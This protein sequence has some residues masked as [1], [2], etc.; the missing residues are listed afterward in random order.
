MN[1]SYNSV[2]FNSIGLENP[3][4]L[5]DESMVYVNK[6]WINQRNIN[7]QGMMTGNFNQITTKQTALVNMFSTDF[8]TL[9]V[10]SIPS[11]TYCK[12]NNITFPESNYQNILNYSISLLSYGDQFNYINSGVLDPVNEISISENNDGTFVVS[13]NASA[14][15]INKSTSALNAAKNFVN[16]L[17]GISQYN[18]GS[19]EQFNNELNNSSF[20]LKNFSE[21]IDRINGSCSIKE[22]YIFNS[23]LNDINPAD[24]ILK[25]SVE[26]R[27]GLRDDFATADVRGTIEYDKN[28]QPD[29]SEVSTLANDGTFKGKA[30]AVL[31]GS[32]NAI[33]ESFN[34]NTEKGKLDFNF[35]Y[36]NNV[37]PQPYFD[38]KLSFKYDKIYSK[39]V[40]DIS[41]PVIVKGNLDQRNTQ[42]DAFL[43]AIPNMETYLYN[44]V[45][46]DYST[47]CSAVGSN[48]Y[49]LRP[50]ANNLSVRR[51]LPKGTLEI[52][53][54]FDDGITAWPGFISN[55]FSINYNPT[56]E[57][58]YPKP[59]CLQNGYYILLQPDIWT[60]PNLSIRANGLL[61]LG[62]E[63]NAEANTKSFEQAIKTA[64]TNALAT[65]EI[66]KSE[67]ISFNNP[68][69]LLESSINTA[70]TSKTK[71]QKHTQV[72]RSII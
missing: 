9:Q 14:R 40:I 50:R 17:K 22:D 72:V 13:H 70:Y 61:E 24:G 1:I 46:S 69:S 7:L 55:S 28:V 53:A 52:S 59:N 23:N 6:K 21:S 27:S 30:E 62:Q 48:V 20:V 2:T 35:T 67:T 26:Y 66:A 39:T 29:A 44:I 54:N 42:L 36:I 18:I 57:L 10:D 12:V 3:Y 68:A 45:N 63:N 15:G 49:I 5:L 38:Y 16:S 43:A 65:T 56:L 32:V 60:L 25:Y 11:F 8:K 71:N 37:I 31:G 64:C 34:I 33:P 4:L 41:G 47:W 19:L 58:I 51:S